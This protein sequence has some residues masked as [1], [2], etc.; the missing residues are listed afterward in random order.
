MKFHLAVL[1]GANAELN[2][3]TADLKLTANDDISLDGTSIYFK[4]NAGNDIQINK[5]NLLMDGYIALGN[6]SISMNGETQNY[7]FTNTRKTQQETNTTNISTLQT[8][9]STLQTDVSTLQTDV[10]TLQ[11]DIS[12]LETDIAHKS[13]KH[14]IKHGRY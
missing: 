2:A 8:D 12:T 14:R 3:S 1:D 5:G 11:T 10:S 4:T 6:N 9:V 7:A 13:N